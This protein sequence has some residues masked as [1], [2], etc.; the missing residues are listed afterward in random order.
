[1]LHVT[2]TH[3]HAGTPSSVD[4]I[5]LYL[6]QSPTGFMLLILFTYCTL[7]LMTNLPQVNTAQILFTTSKR[8][9]IGVGH[10]Q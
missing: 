3:K 5:I 7:Q 2:G 8:G 10:M 4:V 1:M 6:T 9:L